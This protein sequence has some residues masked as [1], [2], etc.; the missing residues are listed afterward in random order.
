MGRGMLLAEAKANKPSQAP[1]IHLYPH[2][3]QSLS[4]KSPS[5]KHFY[6]AVMGGL[7]KLDIHCSRMSFSDKVCRPVR[8]M[9]NRAANNTRC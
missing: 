4:C 6:P 7:V 2:A 5:G 9:L 3:D 8:L 1:Q